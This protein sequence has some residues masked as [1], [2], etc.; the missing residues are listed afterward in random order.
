MVTEMASCA[1]LLFLYIVYGYFFTRYRTVVAS[2]HDSEGVLVVLIGLLVSYSRSQ[3]Q[4]VIRDEKVL[5]C[6][7]NKF[8]LLDS[9][10]QTIC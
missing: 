9:C 1:L 5:V 10:L 4:H 6:A 3:F 7:L 2:L 8:I